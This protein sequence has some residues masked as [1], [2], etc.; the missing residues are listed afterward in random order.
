MTLWIVYLVVALFALVRGAGLF[1]TGAKKVG[2]SLGMSEFSIG[3]SIGL[4]RYFYWVL[5]LLMSGIYFLRQAVVKLLSRCRQVAGRLWR[6]NQSSL[7]LLAL[8]LS[9]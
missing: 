7:L 3:Q 9:L 4:K 6:Q 2:A 1:V 8:P 5:L